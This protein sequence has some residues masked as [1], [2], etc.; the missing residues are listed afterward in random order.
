MA[1][2]SGGQRWVE[3][4][5]R[6]GTDLPFFYNFIRAILQSIGPW[7]PPKRKYTFTMDNLNVHKDPL[8]LNLITA[9]GYGY[10]FRCPYRPQDGPIEY[11]FNAVETKLKSRQFRIYNDADM[12]REMDDII[13]SFDTFV[14]YFEVAGFRT[15]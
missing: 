12:V 10:V 2:T 15:L 1:I 3:F 11:V 9:M 13:R 7:H 4:E 14:S 8:I 6:P 5:E